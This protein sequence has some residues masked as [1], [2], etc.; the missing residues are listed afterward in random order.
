MSSIYLYY[1]IKKSNSTKRPA[2]TDTFVNLSGNFKEPCSV[3]TPV[4]R[5]EV[6]T[7]VN[8][9]SDY[10]N[11]AYIPDFLR[12]YYITDI[13]V[14]SQN[15][16]EL[17]MT[18]DVLG[19]YKTLIGNSTQFVS[20]SAAARNDK[21]TDAMY[22][23]TNNNTVSNENLSS[24]LD[25]WMLHPGE[26][27]DGYYV[28]G[29]INK[30]VNAIG[31]ASYYVMDQAGF[32][33]LRNKL[34]NDVSY[35]QMTFSEIEEALYKSLFNP[36]QYIV[37]CVWFPIKPPT[38]AI[39]SFTIDF[40]FFNVPTLANHMW[41]LNG[42]SAYYQ[43]GSLTTVN[44]PQ[45][46]DG[47]YFQYEPF[48]RRKL[49]LQP[50]GEIELDCSKITDIN[51]VLKIRTWID[52]T[53]GDIVVRVVNT[54]EG[55]AI[56]GGAASKL[57]VPI[58][59][60]QVSQDVLGY[61]AAKINSVVGM[62]TAIAGA[63]SLGV[64]IASGSSVST[65]GGLGQVSS[66][67]K[68][69]VNGIVN[70]AQ[71]FAP[72]VVSSGTNGSLLSTIVEPVYEVQFFRS[73][74]PDNVRLG[75]PLCDSRQISTLSANGG[76]IKCENARITTTAGLYASELSTIESYMNAGFFYE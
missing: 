51:H 57:G 24:V 55:D 10:Y 64:G 1:F 49:I 41:Y 73:A 62:G 8:L 37:S 33:S 44:H 39:G 48:T 16:A 11:Y 54:A 17:H 76:F 29:I 27:S 45:V 4:V 61:E 6:P 75:S 68:E 58:A 32:A 23:V 20:R 14:I 56:C 46:S 30:N 74:Q 21:I 65:V 71:A 26:I 36:F 12:Y 38:S 3:T 5:V 19:S 28:I 31:A 42:T 7:G 47:T 50:F 72:K 69:T 60:A 40:G 34:L 59:L 35:S 53:T 63:A 25:W 9:F 66:G 2:I 15:I 22:P 67:I 18:V 13:I 43:S 70:A 52:F